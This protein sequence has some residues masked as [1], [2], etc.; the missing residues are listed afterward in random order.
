MLHDGW[1]SS[2]LDFELTVMSLWIT[3][4]ILPSPSGWL[5][6]LQPSSSSSLYLG[7]ECSVCN[8]NIPAQAKYWPQQKLF[9]LLYF[10]CHWGWLC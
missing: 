8:V 7:Q 6:M 10:S 4:L 3:D 5:C 1:E 2:Q 9:W